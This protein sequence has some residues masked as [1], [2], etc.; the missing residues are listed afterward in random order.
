MASGKSHLIASLCLNAVVSAICYNQLTNEILI[1]GLFIGAVG[2]MLITPD[3]DLEGVTETERIVR[4][5]I[6]VGDVW[7]AMWYPYALWNPHRG[8]SHTWIGT[9][10]RQLYFIGII[11]VTLLFIVGVQKTLSI[12]TLD[13]N[14]VM[15]GFLPNFPVLCIAGVVWLLHDILHW[16]LDL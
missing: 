13:F 14:Y 8:R 1:E 10:E 12:P 16:I 15:F 2:G 11:F 5:I 9:I 7:V 6:F 3:Y 4:K